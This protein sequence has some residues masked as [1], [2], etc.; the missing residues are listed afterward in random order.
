M[1]SKRSFISEVRSE[2]TIQLVKG[3][4]IYSMQAQLARSGFL[5]EILK[6]GESICSVDESQ[7]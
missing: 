3:V 1:G 2:T 4:M 5:E 7:D 6:T